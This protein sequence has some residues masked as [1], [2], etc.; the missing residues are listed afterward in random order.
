MASTA[1]PFIFPAVRVGDDYYMDGSVRQITPLSPALHL[2]G[3]R[4]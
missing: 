1:I 3:L 2:G 4:R